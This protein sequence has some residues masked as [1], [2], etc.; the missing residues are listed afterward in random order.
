MGYY[1]T[2]NMKQDGVYG[3]PFKSLRIAQKQK[4]CIPIGWLSNT[5]P[6]A[7]FL[8][9]GKATRCF[10]KQWPKWLAIGVD[11]LHDGR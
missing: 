6:K 9:A 3:K 11:R 2:Y 8:L 5:L 10:R 4:S 1:K 7:V